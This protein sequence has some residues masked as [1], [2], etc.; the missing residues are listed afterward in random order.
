M[1]SSGAY[2]ANLIRRAAL[3]EPDIYALHHPAPSLS[4]SQWLGIHCPLCEVN[5]LCSHA[6]VRSVSG[7]VSPIH[8]LKPVPLRSRRITSVH[9]Y[10][11]HLR[12]PAISALS[13]AV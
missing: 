13:L 12:L 6:Y 11:G 1:G 2:L 5:K 10:Y 9:R 4:H 7:H 3:A 8:Y